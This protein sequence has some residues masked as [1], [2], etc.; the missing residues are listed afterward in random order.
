[1]HSLTAIDGRGPFAPGTSL[2]SA[3]RGIQNPVLFQAAGVRHHGKA[4][5]AAPGSVAEK[6]FHLEGPSQMDITINIPVFTYTQTDKTARMSLETHQPAFADLGGL[7][8]SAPWAYLGVSRSS[9]IAG[10]LGRTPTITVDWPAA[11]SLHN[12]GGKPIRAGEYVMFVAPDV[13]SRRTSSSKTAFVA[14]PRMVAL[15]SFMYEWKTVVDAVNEEFRTASDLVKRT[16]GDAAALD[17]AQTL[18]MIQAEVLE[19]FGLDAVTDADVLNDTRA[20]AKVREDLKEIR[21]HLANGMFPVKAGVLNQDPVQIHHQARVGYQAYVYYF[22]QPLLRRRTSTEWYLELEK[23]KSSFLAWVFDA[24]E[25]ERRNRCGGRALTTSTGMSRMHRQGEYDKVRGET[26]LHPHYP[27]ELLC[28][29]QGRA[30][31]LL[32]IQVVCVHLPCGRW[33]NKV[34]PFWSSPGHLHPGQDALLE[35]YVPGGSVSSFVGIVTQTTINDSVNVDCNTRTPPM[36]SSKRSG[37]SEPKYQPVNANASVPSH[38]QG[39]LVVSVF[40]LIVSTGMLAVNLYIASEVRQE[41][42]DLDVSTTVPMV[43]Q[44]LTRVQDL[45]KVRG[46]YP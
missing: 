40:L 29:R 34:F 10:E 46:S 17:D 38:V 7:P 8:V 42:N 35:K 18:D 41:Y 36:M 43:Q 27:C 16:A 44:I 39:L 21:N 25:K 31:P 23:Q 32:S 14:R 15:R 4:A 6:E 2:P 11:T 19:K 45:L 12:N 5:K 1:M 3:H 33:L 24:A 28:S 30:I 20:G 13:E 37:T 9:M 26:P 22:L